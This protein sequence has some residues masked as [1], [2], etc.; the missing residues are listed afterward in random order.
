MTR[1]LQPCRN[2]SVGSASAVLASP[3]FWPAIALDRSTAHTDPL[4]RRMRVAVA[5]VI[6]MGT[7]ALFLLSR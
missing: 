1:V 2:S 6:A 4:D 5:M 3:D 7:G